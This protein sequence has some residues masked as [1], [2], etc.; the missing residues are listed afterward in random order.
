MPMKKPSIPDWNVNSAA[1]FHLENMTLH[2]IPS[3]F[4]MQTNHHEEYTP[5]KVQVILYKYFIY[6]DPA[7]W[8]IQH[9]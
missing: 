7:Y 3:L 4:I 8:Y 2:I 5:R 6:N 9:F 1:T